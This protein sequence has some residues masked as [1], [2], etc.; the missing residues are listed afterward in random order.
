MKK[1]LSLL[2]IVL[3][4]SHAFSQR[5]I[6]KTFLRSYSVLQLDSILTAKGIPPVFNLTYDIDIYKVN[7]HTVSYD[8][9]TTTAS[10]LMTV[11]KAAI[12]REFPMASYFHGTIAQKDQ[13]PS[14]LN[15]D[16]PVIGMIMASIGYITAEPDYLGLPINMHRLRPVHQ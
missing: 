8:S 5:I 10:G 9:S 4:I 14:S 12:C 7:Y 1:T 16:E 13:A 3:S 15:G 2:V 6:S 11:P